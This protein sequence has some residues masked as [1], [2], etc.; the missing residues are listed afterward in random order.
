M[1]ENPDWSVGWKFTGF[2][3]ADNLRQT[4]MPARDR[5]GALSGVTA[6][7]IVRPEF[8][9]RHLLIQ[10]AERPGGRGQGPAEGFTVSARRPGNPSSSAKE[11]PR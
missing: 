1:E 9:A 4:V 10:R 3:A 8:Y 11:V 6:D 7:W 2:Y 5:K